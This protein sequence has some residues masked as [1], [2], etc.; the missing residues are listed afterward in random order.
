MIPSY[1]WL[2]E[3][4]YPLVGTTS[5][6]GGKNPA[7]AVLAASLLCDDTC[8]IE[9]VP[10]VD[11]IR[12]MLLLMRSIGAKATYA[13]ADGRSIVVDPRGVNSDNPPA[14]L[15]RK[16]RASSYLMGALLGKLGQ[17]EVAYPGGCDIGARTLDQHVKGFAAL[18]A[19]AKDQ[20]GAVKLT[21]NGLRG[22]EIYMDVVTVGGTINLIIAAAKA[23]GTTLIFN[24]AKEPHVVE[25]ANFLNSMG[26]VIKGAGTDVIRVKGVAKLHGSTYAIIPDQIVTGT[27]MIA[28]AATMGDVTI[29]G[30][31]PT[32][33]EALTAKL[34]ESGVRVDYHDDTIRVRSNGAHRSIT[35]KTQAYPGF[36]TDLQQPMTALL[37]TARGISVVTETIFESRFRQLGELARMGANITVD[38]NRAAIT[39]VSSLHGAKITA[40]D[41]R[42]GASLVIAALMAKGTTEICEPIHIDRGYENLTDKLNALGARITIQNA[43]TMEEPA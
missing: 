26:A 29:A 23:E 25:V 32:H 20:L 10:D 1:R 16:I 37:T 18:G 8:V 19:C 6:S 7:L 5:V 28:A 43:D 17:A 42:A 30:C 39:G 27:I 14:E 9:N 21:S 22:A 36:P 3:G 35:L 38:R 2:V 11:D 31:I 41:L 13:G 4:S 40:T 15:A 24:A 34:L 33:M 12:V